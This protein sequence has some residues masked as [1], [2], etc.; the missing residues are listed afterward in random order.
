MQILLALGVSV[1]AMNQEPLQHVSS[2]STD[3][4]LALFTALSNDS[5]F[6]ILRNNL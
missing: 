1:K 5:F 6:L 2:E 4:E 3:P